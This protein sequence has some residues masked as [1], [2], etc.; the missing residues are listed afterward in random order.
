MLTYRGYS[1]VCVKMNYEAYLL[2]AVSI[3]SGYSILFS[4][5]NHSMAYYRIDEELQAA[6][7]L[8]RKVLLLSVV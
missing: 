8:E 6:S 2:Y 7:Y 3:V 5:Y 1:V 4:E